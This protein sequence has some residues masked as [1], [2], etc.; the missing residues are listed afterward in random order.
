MFG[1]IKRLLGKA[2]K[3]DMRLKPGEVYVWKEVFGLE[4]SVKRIVWIYKPDERKRINLDWCDYNSGGCNPM[5][6]GLEDGGVIRSHCNLCGYDGCRT[7]PY[8]TWRWGVELPKGDYTF[9]GRVV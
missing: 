8:G 6:C 1:C 3:E 2:T 4:M 9:K 5:D 7:K